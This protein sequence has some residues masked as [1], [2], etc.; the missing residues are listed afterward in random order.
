MVSQPAAG[1]FHSD[2]EPWVGLMSP[3]PFHAAIL[4]DLVLSIQP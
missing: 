1:S 3:L 4:A 2:V